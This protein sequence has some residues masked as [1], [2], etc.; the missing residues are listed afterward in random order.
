MNLMEK[1]SLKIVWWNVNNFYHFDADKAEKIGSSRWPKSRDE[2]DRKCHL[3]DK[4]FGEMFDLVGPIDMLCLCEISKKAAE[5]LR[6]RILPNFRVVSLDVKEDDPTL[7]VAILFAPDSDVSKYVERPPII[8]PS[9]PRGT[10]PMAVI[11][12]QVLKHKIRL[13]ACHWQARI[14]E[15]KS[16]VFR[17]R[18]ADFLG[19]HS[20]D[21][22]QEDPSLNHIV[23]LGDL[24]EE[25]FEKNLQILNAHRHRNRSLKK[26]HWADHD[27][28]RVHLYNTSWRQLGEKHPYPSE[29]GSLA[30][31][32][33]CAGTYYWEDKQSWH[34]FDQLIVSGGLLTEES[35]FI[36]ENEI[37]IISL[38]SLLTDGLPLKFSHRGSEYRGLSDH[39]PLF[40]KISI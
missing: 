13:I 4:A 38:P 40:A 20:Y 14:D 34:H 23:I 32:Q 28:K 7:Q 17:S 26:S 37:S 33:D 10:R 29:V 25:P 11:E 36:D 15:E 9:M 35:P 18:S 3:V 1:K 19:M 8:V 12:I 2:Y 6:D 16:E 30:N 31:M 5:Q 27:V 22:I 39:L 24:N 21:F